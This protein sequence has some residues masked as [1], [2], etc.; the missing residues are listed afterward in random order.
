MFSGSPESG[1]TLVGFVEWSEVA[2]DQMCCVCFPGMRRKVV[3]AQLPHH[4][5]Q[6]TMGG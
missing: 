6:S 4:I 3:S 2:L 1:D 5:I